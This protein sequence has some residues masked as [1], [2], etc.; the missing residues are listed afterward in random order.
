MNTYWS[1]ETHGDPLGAI[2]E[3]VK[4][5][6]LE[7]R[8]DGML[9]T[10]NGSH[11]ASAKPRLVE[12]PEQLAE[13]N[14][15]KP[16][17][18]V[19]AARLVP[20]LLRQHPQARLGALLRPCEMRALVEMTKHAS[21]SLDNLLTIS[22]DC[23]GTLPAEEYQWRAERA[24]K[25]HSDQTSDSLA[26]EALQ[27]ARQGG[28]VAYRYRS[29]CQFCSAPDARNADL[30]IHVLGLPV[31]QHI[32][33]QARD[34]AASERYVLTSITDGEANPELVAQHVHLL[35]K[36]STRHQ[37]TLQT[38]TEG[39]GSLLAANAEALIAQLE[40]CGDCQTCMNVC[41]I[42]SV[43]RPARG[44]DG[45]YARRE[46]MR[47][48]VSCAGCGMCEQSCPNRLPL[49]AIFTHLSQ[50]FAEPSAYLPGRSAGEPLP[51]V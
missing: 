8:L 39:L 15:F 18:T 30:N 40:Q 44:A 1:L 50:Q 28:I 11:T 12:D 41:P 51:V 23:L 43:D 26:Q 22:V 14:V 31:R 19:N 46:V 34:R 24:E 48:L 9:V 36:M 4:T 2:R 20:D 32:L 29:A 13:V 21:F 35:A 16:L 3:C 7:A 27:F 37:N 38:I 42:C 5:V 25:L 45:K 49:A 47:W 17:M 6:W 33:V 10:P